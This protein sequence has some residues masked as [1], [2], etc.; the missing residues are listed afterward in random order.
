MFGASRVLP[1]IPSNK[2]YRFRMV[3]RPERYALTVWPSEKREPLA[4][5]DL[6]QPVD[7]LPRGSV[8]IIAHHCAV[9]V[10]DFQVSPV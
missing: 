8:G 3:V 1:Q 10:Y 6:R 7:R 5:L 2:Q 4:Q 9:R